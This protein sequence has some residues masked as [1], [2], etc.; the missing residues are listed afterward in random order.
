MI[1]PPLWLVILPIAATPVVYLTRR[2]SAGTYVAAL[3][4]LLTGL[5]AWSLPPTNMMRLM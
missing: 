1:E 4:S 3:A 2:W 5:L